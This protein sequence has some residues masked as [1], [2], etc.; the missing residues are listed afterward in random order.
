VCVDIIVAGVP[1]AAEQP[2]VRGFLDVA[3][4]AELC[5]TTCGRFKWLRVG[6]ECGVRVGDDEADGGP[7]DRGESFT[8]EQLREELTRSALAYSGSDAVFKLRC[9]HGVQVKAYAPLL[10]T[11]TLIGDGIMSAAELELSNLRSSTTVA[12]ILEHKVGGVVDTRGGGREGLAALLV[13]FQSAVLYTSPGGRRRVR[14]STLGLPTSKVPADVFRSA[15][16]GTVAAVLTR[17]A[18][19]DVEDPEEGSLH[20]ARSGVLRRCVAI[21]ASYR[22]HTTAKHSPPGKLVLPAELQLLPLFCLS[23]RKSRLFRNNGGMRNRPFPTADERAYHIFYGRMVG[24]NMSLQCVHP[25]LFQ[26][27]DMR[28]KDGEW[29]PP[30]ALGISPDAREAA[31]S[32]AMRPVCQLPTSVNPSIA[33]LDDRGVYLLDDRFVFYLLVGKDVPEETWR[34]LLAAPARAGALA[35]APAP[36]GRQ[37]RNVLWQLRGLNAPNATLAADARHTHAP[38]VL[39]LLGRESAVEEE[40]HGLLVDDPVGREKSYVDFLCDVHKAVLREG[41]HETTGR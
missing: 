40:V 8:G 32:A 10:P 23:I 1:S 38:L 13:L 18:I 14:V 30:P 11:G 26:V 24:P 34:G 22:E 12:V 16:P 21:L 27:S 35:L 4:L 6:N 19:D 3:T 41:G 36:A 5:R 20:N 39:V 7:G 37:L 28:M 29:T 15:D 25:N 9:S 17:Q 33:C 2:H 31:A